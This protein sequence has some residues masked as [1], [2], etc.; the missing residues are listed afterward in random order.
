MNHNKKTDGF[1]LVEAMV[2]FVLMGII[3]IATIANVKISDNYDKLYWQ[4]F[5]TLYQASKNASEKFEKSKGYRDKWLQKANEPGSLTRFDKYPGF[6][7]E[8]ESTDENVNK[9]CKQLTEFINVDQDSAC[10]TGD[11]GA[12][13]YISETRGK[14]GIDFYKGFSNIERGEDETYDADSYGMHVTFKTLNG[15]L[16]YITRVYWANFDPK[17]DK[18]G[19][20]EREAFRFVVVDLNGN[21]KPNT[22]FIKSG[23]NP[24]IVL[25]AIDSQG[26]V[27]PLGLP[28]FSKAYINAMVFY[29]TD[30]DRYGKP[31]YPKVHSKVESLWH[32]K[33]MAW[34]YKEDDPKA[35]SAEASEAPYLQNISE[36]EALSQSTKFYYNAMNCID[37]IE[38]CAVK[39]FK[40]KGAYADKEYIYL[41]SQ[42]L[43]K[44]EG[45]DKIYDY[46]TE[47]ECGTA[48]TSLDS[49]GC[50]TVTKST[51]VPKCGIDFKH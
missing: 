35:C 6:L 44:E 47:D 46:L 1:T 36:Y 27:I 51:T 25:F 11:F 50:N 21:S 49:N 12:N 40:G 24:D 20:K 30:V 41:V 26:N 2:C 15:Q 45:S 10:S 14:V 13:F 28:E 16:F 5:N 32:A 38:S 42:F 23:R 7:Q 8:E 22:Q 39:E 19:M 31:I 37:K 18:F 29:P 43:Y 17:N 48:N 4:A 9:F 33:K 3:F 34:G